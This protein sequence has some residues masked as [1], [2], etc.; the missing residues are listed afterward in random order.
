MNR[1]FTNAEP[2]LPVNT[3]NG[4]PL[5]TREM[6]ISNHGGKGPQTTKTAKMTGEDAEQRGPS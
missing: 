3:E 2:Q 5:A 6:H 1:N 4:G